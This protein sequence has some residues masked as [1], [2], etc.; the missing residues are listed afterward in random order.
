MP[1]ISM[2]RIVHN[3]KGLFLLAAIV[4]AAQVIPSMG[5]SPKEGEPAGSGEESQPLPP[6]SGLPRLVDV[7]ADKCIPCKMMAPILDELRGEYSGIFEVHFIDVW[8]N[9]GAG[10]GFA[11]RIIPTQIFYDGSG[12]E[13]ERHIGF[14]SKEDILATWKKLGINLKKGV[15][16]EAH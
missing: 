1:E 3:L 7:G 13:L 4:T 12:K 15:I 8:K 5:C 2:K 11:V 6:P 10:K 14:I 9:P 16:N